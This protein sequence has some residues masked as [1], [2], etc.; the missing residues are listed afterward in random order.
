MSILAWIVLGLLA[1]FIGSKLVNKTGEGIVLDIVLGI[2]GAVVGGYLFNMMGA[3]GVTGLNIYSL[4]VAVVGA[5]SCWSRITPSVAWRD[6]PHVSAV[7]GSVH[8]A[9]ACAH[10]RHPDAARQWASR[11]RRRDQVCLYGSQPR[12]RHH[13]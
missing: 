11:P 10:S 7:A 2:T 13:S 5:C 8:D 6:S 9:D 1:G 3:A 12:R 4:F